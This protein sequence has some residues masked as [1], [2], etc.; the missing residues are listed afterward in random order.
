MKILYIL[1]FGH[2]CFSFDYVVL[3]YPV[4]HTAAQGGGA[5]V[6][7]RGFLWGTTAD[8]VRQFFAGCQVTA[9]AAGASPN[10]GKC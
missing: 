4:L 6:R 5:V 2:L 8:T 3:K 10:N 9:G 7:A 1:L